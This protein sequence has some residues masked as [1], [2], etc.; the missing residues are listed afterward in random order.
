M[1]GLP[2]DHPLVGLSLDLLLRSLVRPQRDCAQRSVLVI[3]VA[4]VVGDHDAHVVNLYLLLDVAVLHPEVVD[5]R[6]P[7]V[8]FSPAID[9]SGG[10][11]TARNKSRASFT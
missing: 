2:V 10:G 3:Y 9:P 11:R 1:Y 6:T 8:M 5:S 4:S 7:V